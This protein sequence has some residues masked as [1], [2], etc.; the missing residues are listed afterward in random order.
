[1]TIIPEHIFNDGTDINS[2]K[3]NRFPLGT[4]PYR[5]EKWVTGSRIS[6]VRNDNYYGKKPAIN[7]IVFRVVPE[8]NVALQM[9][10]KGDLEVMGI[11][12]IQWV[13]QTN[14]EKFK[15]SFYKFEYYT[16]NYSYIGWNARR[17]PFDDRRV[18][19]AIGYFIN[20]DDILKKLSFG[21]GKRV[22]GTFF[23]KSK[24]YNHSLV[25]RKYNHKKGRRLLAEAG[26]QDSDNDGW[27]DKDGKKFTFT[28]TISSGSKFAERL[29]TI[30]KEDLSKAGIDMEINR[31]EWAVFV[32]K[33][34]KR[35]FDAV[36]LRWSLGYNE[37]ASFC[38][39]IP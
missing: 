21:L 7:R 14:S 26:W 25:P 23:I 9:L 30:M 27:I 32:Q 37:A 12:A 1:M 3:N 34:N 17:K 2:H 28:F 38:L 29:A 8:A 24:Y 4:G 20:R 18:R 13:R 10:K 16:P 31:F 39:I 36:I 6:L 33:L 35:D 15:N 5:F 11:R 19:V 22:A